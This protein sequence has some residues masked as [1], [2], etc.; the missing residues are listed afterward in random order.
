MIYK[1]HHDVIKLMVNHSGQRQNFGVGGSKID[2]F[3]LSVFQ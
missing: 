2:L 1:Y 3:S